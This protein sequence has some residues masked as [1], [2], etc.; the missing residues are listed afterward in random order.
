MHRAA[1]ALLHSHLYGRYHGLARELVKPALAVVEYVPLVAK[2]AQTAVRVAVGMRRI[3]HL[4]VGQHRAPAAAD[5]G[6]AIR[7]R[8]ERIVG[9]GI[10]KRIVA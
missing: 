9:I 3:Y 4:A 10:R 5:D 7:P 6:S 1:F 2:A 8:P